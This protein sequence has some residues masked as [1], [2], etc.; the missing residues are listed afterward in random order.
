MK[1]DEIKITT[2]REI[3]ICEHA[4]SKLEKIIASMERK[5]GKGSKDFFRELEGT[6]HPYDSDI[7][8]WYESFSALTRWKERLAAHQEIMKL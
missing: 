5:Y 8:H 3:N 4:I 1:Y 6:P 7:V 2:R